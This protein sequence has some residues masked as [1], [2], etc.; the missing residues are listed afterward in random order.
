MVSIL[1]TYHS[2][3]DREVR[4]EKEILL[5]VYR[6]STRL[7]KLFISRVSRLLEVSASSIAAIVVSFGISIAVD[8]IALS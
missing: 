5:R 2:A 1:N 6:E 7:R 3:V 8:S 4:D